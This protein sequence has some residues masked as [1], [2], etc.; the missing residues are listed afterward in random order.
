MHSKIRINK[1]KTNLVAQRRY[2]DGTNEVL[3]RNIEQELQRMQTELETYFIGMRLS[4]QK[5]NVSPNLGT[6]K[7]DN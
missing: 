1:Q 4:G 5:Q 7:L 6:P 2:Y 3:F